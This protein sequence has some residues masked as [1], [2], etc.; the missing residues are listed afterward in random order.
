MDRIDELFERE[1]IRAVLYSYCYYVDANQ[2]PDI[3]ALFT[4]DC[5]FDWGHARA[6]RGHLGIAELMSALDVWSATSHHLSNVLVTFSND[7][8]AAASSYI[9]AWHR[10]RAT[11]EEQ[12]LWGRYQD[13]L[14]RESNGWRIRERQLR[15]AG[16]SGFL[17]PDGL[18]SN[19]ERFERGSKPTW[20]RA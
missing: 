5:V 15:S 10:V 12:R 8:T 17:S 18:P 3:V 2:V 9:Y 11:G 1:A 16:E 19:F 7:Q 14:H 20:D 6:A 13:S 4:E